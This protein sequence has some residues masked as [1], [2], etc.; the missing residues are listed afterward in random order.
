MEIGCL[1]HRWHGHKKWTLKGLN[2]FKRYS[3]L[4]EAEDR[5]TYQHSTTPSL[6]PPLIPYL[7]PVH[8]LIRCGVRIFSKGV[9]VET[10]KTP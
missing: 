3:K 1:E 2:N 10:L 7:P 5:S 6:D 8:S 9:S 4:S